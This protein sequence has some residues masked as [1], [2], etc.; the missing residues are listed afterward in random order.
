MKNNYKLYNNMTTN[1]IIQQ[2]V[3][4][5]GAIVSSDACSEME[6]A[7]AQATGRFA[8]DDECFGYVRRTKEW[9]ALHMA[10]EKAH[11]NMDYDNEEESALL[12]AI[13]WNEL[14]A[15]KYHL[16]RSL[17][18]SERM[19]AHAD[20]FQRKKDSHNKDAKILNG[21]LAFHTQSKI[22]GDKIVK[23]SEAYTRS[24]YFKVTYVC[25]IPTTLDEDNA[26]IRAHI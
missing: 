7:D 1:Q 17:A 13:E 26:E 5:G 19:T 6:I 15:A 12:R 10:R 11:K 24:N 14:S 18:V 4:E 21:L 23:P 8:V 2:L 20:F 16:E 3:S 22:E 25:H 9:L